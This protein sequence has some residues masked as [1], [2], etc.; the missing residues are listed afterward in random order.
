MRV[1]PP[2]ALLTSLA[3]VAAAQCAN[4]SPPPCAPL[5]IAAPDPSRIAVFAN[6]LLIPQRDS[7][8]AELARLE[9]PKR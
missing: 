7:V 1:V 5:T 6:A 8:A 2:L 9:A 3:R 4:G